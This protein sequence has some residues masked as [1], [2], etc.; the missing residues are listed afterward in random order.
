VSGGRR[1]VVFG[2]TV[3]DIYPDEEVVAGSPLHVAAHLAGAGWTVWLVTRVG[4]DAH[5]ERI[6]AAIAAHGIDASLVETDPELPS[7]RVTVEAAAEANTFRIH[8]P[9]AWDA[10]E[11]PANL[12]PHEV[13]AYG[14]LVGRA[15][16]ARAALAR[17]LSRSRARHRVLDLN[18]RP[19]DVDAGVL[20]ATLASATAVKLSEEEL[21]RTGALL[22][23]EPDP[24]RLLQSLPHLECVC[25]TQGARGAE[26]HDRTGRTRID[27]PPVEV[28]NT[29]GAGDAFAAG[30]IDGLAR[31]A[32]REET[33]AT[34]HAWAASV[35][36]R[37][38]GLP[39]P[40]DDAL[41]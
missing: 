38:G 18:L 7:G 9:A 6:R 17:L 4:R 23:L 22:G 39:E 12:P 1:A 31:G 15:P 11:G 35:L 40:P 37:R 19:P 34:A 27:P 16:R 5:G 36:G 33:L 29:V 14:T 26:L 3:V 30:L 2:E 13:L 25:V 24:A 8:G 10:L 28:V 21:D 32:T 41:G 20:R